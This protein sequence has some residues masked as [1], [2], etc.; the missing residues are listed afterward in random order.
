MEFPILILANTAFQTLLVQTLCPGPSQVT[1]E[2]FIS[3]HGL[4]IFPPEC[5][6][7][8][9]KYRSCPEAIYLIEAGVWIL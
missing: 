9:C 3:G 1:L 2:E 4:K 8:V 7:T 6:R 5:E